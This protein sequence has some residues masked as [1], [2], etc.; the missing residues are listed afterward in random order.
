MASARRQLVV[1]PAFG[2]GFKT[3][4]ENMVLRISGVNKEMLPQK[5]SIRAGES[6]TEKGELQGVV[7]GLKIQS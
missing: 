2:S 6:Q 5:S 4:K 3:T 1:A 7:Y